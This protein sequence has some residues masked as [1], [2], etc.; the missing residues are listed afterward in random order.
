MAKQARNDVVSHARQQ[1]Q[2][3]VQAEYMTP[4]RKG[5]GEEMCEFV[6]PMTEKITKGKAREPLAGGKRGRPAASIRDS[7]VFHR[8]LTQDTLALEK[9]LINASHTQPD[10]DTREAGLYLSGLIANAAA[11]PNTVY[12]PPPTKA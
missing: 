10:K 7:Q 3:A 11:T 2:A 8:D 5:K 9:L 6:A 1:V 12:Q 4:Q